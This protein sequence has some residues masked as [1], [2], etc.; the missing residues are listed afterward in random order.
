MKIK[1]R[2]NIYG[3]KLFIKKFVAVFS[4]RE[5]AFIYCLLGT[6]GQIFHTYYLIYSVSSFDGWIR[7]LQ[8]VLLSI[9]ISSAL[10]YFVSI[11]DKDDPDKKEFKRIMMAVNLFMYIEI[12]INLYY[13][14]N[15]L[16]IIS[17]EMRI[18]DFLFGSIVS[19]LIPISIKLFANSIKAKLWIQEIETN[20]K[21]ESIPIIK[22]DPLSN[23]LIDN[24]F[25]ELTNRIEKYIKGEFK[26]IDEYIKTTLKE[27]LKG[28]NLENLIG[29][30]SIDHELIK[31]DIESDIKQYVKE[32]IDKNIKLKNISTK[33]ISTEEIDK[34][35]HKDIMDKIEELVNKNNGEFLKNIETKIETAIK[36]YVNVKPQ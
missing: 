13:Y 27:K 9:F 28:Q 19:A 31:S 25:N 5:F 6:I 30:Y 32:Y 20:E 7:G 15:H 1:Q 2:F 3:F 26:T 14:C 35:Y 24:I 22:N 36:Q 4:S 29:N 21:R 8:A 10:M 17:S 18:F 34:L 12:L 33:E 11:A 23:Q 16:I